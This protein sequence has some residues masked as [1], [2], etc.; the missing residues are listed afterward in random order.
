MEQLYNNRKSRTAFLNSN[1]FPS[2]FDFF[3]DPVK[4]DCIPLNCVP[5]HSVLEQNTSLDIIPCTTKLDNFFK[6]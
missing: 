4:Y 3:Y 5:G 2:G 1:H 6:M